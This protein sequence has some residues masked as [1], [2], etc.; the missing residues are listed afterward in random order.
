[1]NNYRKIYNQ[2]H[3]YNQNADQKNFHGGGGVIFNVRIQRE[4]IEG[5]E[6]IPI[7]GKFKPPYFNKVE[8]Q[9]LGLGRIHPC[10]PENKIISQI[11]LP[12]GKNILICA[13]AGTNLSIYLSDW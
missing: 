5:V 4:G 11:P 12:T 7:H 13:R 9:K 6:T 1:M 2:G 10:P 8:L 3:F